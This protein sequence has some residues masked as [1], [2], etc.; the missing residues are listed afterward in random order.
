MSRILSFQHVINIKY[1]NE[2]LHPFFFP[3]VNSSSQD[4]LHLIFFPSTSQFGLAHSK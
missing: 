4:D 2:T 3:V 1:I